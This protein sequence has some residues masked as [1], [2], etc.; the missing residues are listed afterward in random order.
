MSRALTSSRFPS[1]ARNCRRERTAR[2][3]TDG[4]LSLSV[5]DN[6]LWTRWRTDLGR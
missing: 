3:P 5:T 1:G 2:V 4:Q 6:P